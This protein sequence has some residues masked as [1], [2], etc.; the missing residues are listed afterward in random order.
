MEQNVHILFF[1][2]NHQSKLFSKQISDVHSCLVGFLSLLHVSD[3]ATKVYIYLKKAS[4][5]VHFLFGVV[6]Y[7]YSIINV[8]TA[9]RWHHAILFGG[10]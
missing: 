2:F 6:S 3:M 10:L 7:V 8:Y 4:K 9:T 1:P 5:C